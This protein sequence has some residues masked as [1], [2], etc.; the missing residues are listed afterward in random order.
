MLDWLKEKKKKLN[1]GKFAPKL[2]RKK[3]T[4][5]WSQYK[6]TERN[7][8]NWEEAFERGKEIEKKRSD[9]EKLTTARNDL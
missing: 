4:L 5:M 1:Y 6:K 2:K 3:E 9:D 8:L 7:V